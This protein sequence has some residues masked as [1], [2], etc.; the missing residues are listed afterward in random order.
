MHGEK[1]RRFASRLAAEHKAM[2][3][4]ESFPARLP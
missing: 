2:Q 1:S 4:T 3:L